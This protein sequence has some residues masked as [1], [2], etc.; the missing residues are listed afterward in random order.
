MNKAV[1]HLNRNRTYTDLNNNE[2][3]DN[4]NDVIDNEI[5]LTGSG[6]ALDESESE[7]SCISGSEISE[8]NDEKLNLDKSPLSSQLRNEDSVDAGSAGGGT[9]PNMLTRRRKKKRRKPACSKKPLYKLPHFALNNIQMIFAFFQKFFCFNLN[10]D[11][12]LRGPKGPKS[13]IIS[14]VRLLPDCTADRLSLENCIFQRPPAIGEDIYVY[15]GQ[16]KSSSSSNP[17]STIDNTAKSKNKIPVTMIGN[18]RQ[19]IQN[20]Q[21]KNLRF[22]EEN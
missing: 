3:D 12:S 15:L 8:E 5:L 17:K 10:L 21:K 22:C 13:T 19:I 7:D 2:D 1:L 20:C 14:S 6:S 4:H 11:N 16:R 18:S 9:G